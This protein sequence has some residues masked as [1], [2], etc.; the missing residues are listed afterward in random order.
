MM[1]HN[2]HCRPRCVPARP[3]DLCSQGLITEERLRNL[4]AAVYDRFLVDIH[5]H[6]GIADTEDED[7]VQALGNCYFGDGKTDRGRRP[8]GRLTMIERFIRLAYA[9]RL[10]FAE[11]RTYGPISLNGL[12]LLDA[13]DDVVNGAAN[14]DWRVDR[15]CSIRFD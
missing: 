11:M 10:R 13:L 8:S 3:I 7:F 12:E 4:L 9:C 1:P 6:R 14:F 2:R 15:D 5:H